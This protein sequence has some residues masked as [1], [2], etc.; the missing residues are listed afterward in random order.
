VERLKEIVYGCLKNDR[1]KQAE[2]YKMFA[3]KMY[4]VCLRYTDNTPDAQ[5]ILQEGFLKVFDNLK[6]FKW[7]GS[8]EGWMK[9][10]FVNMALDRYRKSITHL[11]VEDM[12]E[13]EDISDK[14]ASALDTLSEKEIL[15]LIQQLPDQYRLV[16]NLSIIEGLSHQ[17]IAEML[18]IGVSTSRSNL[19]RAKAILKEKIEYQTRWVEKAI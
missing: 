1:H 10:I 7:E 12:H 11:S 19:A 14:D 4:G 15:I 9:R 3:S 8:L 17:Q 2:L 16:F 6:N 18:N 13:A 5:D